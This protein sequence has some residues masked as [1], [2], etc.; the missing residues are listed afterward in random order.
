MALTCELC[1]NP[2]NASPVGSRAT[3]AA[4][5]LPHTG[6]TGAEGLAAEQ[7]LDKKCKHPG[8]KRA[9]TTAVPT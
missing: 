5:V 2:K 7:N 9:D 4:C 1:E 3:C 8:S 6:R